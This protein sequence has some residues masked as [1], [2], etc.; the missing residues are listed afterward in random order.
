MEGGEGI[1]VSRQCKV[2]ITETRK[3]NLFNTAEGRT[4][5]QML[6]SDRQTHNILYVPTLTFI[7]Y[8]FKK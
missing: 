8:S 7:K 4:D 6:S 1:I 5:L 3:K 2:N